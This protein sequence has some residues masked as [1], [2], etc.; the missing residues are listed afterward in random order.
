[1][2]TLRLALGPLT[3]SLSPRGEREAIWRLM[4][5]LVALCLTGHIDPTHF[6]G[7]LTEEPADLSDIPVAQLTPEQLV[8]EHKRLD[9]YR[10]EF[11]LPTVLS[12]VGAVLV[13]LGGVFEVLGIFYV[14]LP[15]LVGGS[16]TGLAAFT[17]AGY[18][19]IAL[20]ATALIA[21][22]ILL[23]IGLIKLFPALSRRR[24]AMERRDEIQKRL[25]ASDPEKQPQAPPMNPGDV[26]YDGPLPSMLLATF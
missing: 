5:A 16:M 4:L 13:V 1:M 10:T 21:G 24:D 9:K 19:L 8:S 26:R 11:V 17:V 7:A 20:G 18:V 12:G 2:L 25:D 22:G 15:S 6:A 23:T 14:F 3:P